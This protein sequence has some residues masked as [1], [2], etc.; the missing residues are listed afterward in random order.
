[1]LKKF[2][3]FAFVILFSLN[4]S[5][6]SAQ[7]APAVNF[8]RLKF[9]LIDFRNPSQLRGRYGLLQFSPDGNY[10]ATTGTERDVKIYDA[11]SGQLK[12]TLDGD[13]NGFNAFSFNPDGKT[14]I[15]QD[16][17]YSE[18]RVFDL[19]T[20]KLL[21]AIDGSGRSAASKKVV[22]NSMKGLGGLEMSAA[23]VT[24]DWTTVLIQRNEGEYELVDTASNTIKYTLKHSE[25]S[26]R[27]RDF[28][29][30]LIVPFPSLAG[31]LIP[32]AAFSP[33]GKRVVIANGNNSPSLWNA[34][35]GNLIAR[36]EPQEDRVYE[37]VFSPDGQLV[38]TFNIKGV[39][40]IWETETGKTLASFGSKKERIAGG[41][42]S[43]DSQKFV[44]ISYKTGFA[45]INF[46]EDTPV[47]DARGGKLLFNLENS[48]SAS[49]FFSPD[50]RLVATDNRED[51]TIMAQIWNAE[52]GA[53]VAKLPRQKDEDRAFGFV[54]SPDGKYL[55]APTPQNVKIWS[56]SGE[57]VQSLENAVFP[58]RFSADG[59]L[60]ATGGKNDV[61]FVW[62]IEGK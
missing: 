40:K 43:A 9:K 12:A 25:K 53:L 26:S 45:S 55:V 44:T 52:T 18:T 62:Q 16:L 39:A 3:I 54:W 57:F 14:A 42:W 51:K 35:D 36:L 50:G 27:V 32:N 6:V 24:P 46:K 49:A 2:F 33:D 7:T 5:A 48:Q 28:L 31:I 20:G 30:S 15:A 37:A 10:L 38:A 1:M 13:R 60:L 47:W 23:P 19:E 17:D 21:K 59:R 22:T 34:A 61:G 41:N 29:K 8:A 56:A 11:K 58:A 4:D